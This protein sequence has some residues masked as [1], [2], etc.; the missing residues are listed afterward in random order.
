MTTINKLTILLALTTFSCNNQSNKDMTDNSIESTSQVETPKT[1]N[2]VEPDTAAA[3]YSQDFTHQQAENKTIQ[4]AD[5]FMG[6]GSFYRQFDKPIQIFTLKANEDKTIV[7]NEGTKITVKSNSFVTE[8]GKP[9]KGII[10]FQVKEYYKTSDILLANLTTSSNNEILETGGMIYI[11]A[12][13]NGE[14]C[15]LKKGELIEISFPSKDRKDDMQLFNGEWDKETINWI[16]ESTQDLNKVYSSAAVDEIPSFPGGENKM[17]EFLS[18]QVKYPKIALDKGIQG[19]VYVGFV[20]GKDG[21]LENVRVL[22]GVDPT[23]DKTAISAVNQMPK[24]KPGKQKG[25]FVNVQFVLPVSFRS[26]DGE[27]KT[28]N[29]QYA[30]DFESKTTNENLQQAEISEISQYIFSA[31]Q[32]GWINCDR[33]YKDNNPKID[34]VINIR[35]AANMDIK[36]VFNEI[37]S[38]LTGLSNKGKY[39]FN[40]VPTGHSI[41]LVALKYENDQYYLAVKKTKIARDEEPTLDFEP[42]TMTRLKIEME[43]L[44]RL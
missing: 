27:F 6:F 2:E 18:K 10:K 30:K 31:S 11:D 16:E 20:V 42:V 39:I 9:V 1:K 28:N 38:I 26:G 5:N 12:F 21:T 33:F 36:I 43:K 14:K 3:T 15:E 40:N 35:N 29:V 34:Y 19:I 41:T 44:N 7:C 22:R 25:E 37:N 4:R 24:W 13:S 8:T 32:L 17:M 23:L